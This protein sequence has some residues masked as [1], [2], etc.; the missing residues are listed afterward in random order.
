MW[1]GRLVGGRGVGSLQQLLLRLAI[2][3]PLDSL[4]VRVLQ[5]V[6]EEA[7]HDAEHKSQGQEEPEEDV[8][9]GGLVAMEMADH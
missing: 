5:N 7:C 1:R 3:L 8:Q 4:L 2:P 6:A 9:L